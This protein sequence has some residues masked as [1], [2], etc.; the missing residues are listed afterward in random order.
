MGKPKINQYNGY[1]GS[2]YCFA[3]HKSPSVRPASK[4][5]LEKAKS[6]SDPIKEGKSGM[7]NNDAVNMKF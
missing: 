4:V 2:V 3:E 6:K 7:K 5:E 1:Y